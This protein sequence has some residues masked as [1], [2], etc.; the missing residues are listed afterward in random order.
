MSCFRNLDGLQFYWS[1]PDAWQHFQSLSIIRFDWR[2]ALQTQLTWEQI[3]YEL[4][5]RVRR[6]IWDKTYVWKTF[7][8]V[9]FSSRI[10]HAY[11]SCQ[12]SPRVHSTPD[13]LI[14]NS[15]N[16]GTVLY[17]GRMV[18]GIAVLFNPFWKRDVLGESYITQLHKVGTDGWIFLLPTLRSS[19]T[20]I[21]E[22]SFCWT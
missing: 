19:S 9:Y 17:Y 22:L 5:R 11:E 7:K 2:F 21:P 15:I 12:N 3:F 20:I 18:D 14:L 4:G 10:L 6:A 8:A 16:N 13:F 1:I